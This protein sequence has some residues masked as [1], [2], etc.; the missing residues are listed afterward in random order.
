MRRKRVFYPIGWD[1][2]GLA[3]ER[4]VQNVTGVRCNPTLPF[5]PDFTAPY[6]GDVPKDHRAIPVSR[7][8]FVRLCHGVL[9]DDA[10]GVRRTRSVANGSPSTGA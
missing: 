5:D 1:D 6:N 9:P 4:R 10:E 2:N 7:P 3:T 8:N